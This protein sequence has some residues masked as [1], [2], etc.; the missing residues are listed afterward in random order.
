MEPPLSLEELDWLQ[1]LRTDTPEK[2][3]VP[4]AVH[5]RLVDA[6]VALELVEGGLQLTDLG[7]ERLRKSSTI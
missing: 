7:R 3:D 6:G 2:P 5:K 4:K 1:K